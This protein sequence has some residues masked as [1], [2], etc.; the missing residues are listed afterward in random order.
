VKVPQLGG[1][2]KIDAVFHIAVPPLTPPLGG[3]G[4]RRGGRG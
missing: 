3:V 2:F 4:R 1:F